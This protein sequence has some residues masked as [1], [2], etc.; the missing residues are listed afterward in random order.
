MKKNLL[1]GILLCLF[2]VSCSKVGLKTPTTGDVSESKTEET[3][4]N[5]NEAPNYFPIEENYLWEYDTTVNETKSDKI[6]TSKFAET[7]E[8]EGEIFHRFENSETVFGW[9]NEET[10][11]RKEGST[12]YFSGFLTIDTY[13]I[14][15]E[16]EKILEDIVSEE[17]IND[18]T[19]S[20]TLDKF[21]FSEFGLSGN[22]TP[23]LEANIHIKYIGKEALEVNG[24]QYNDVLKIQYTVFVKVVVGV[25]VS[26]V[27]LLTHTLI[28]KSPV[29]TLTQ[30][31]ANHIGCVKSILNVDG[32]AITFNN[33]IT[34]LG[35][36]IDASSFTS[37]IEEQVKSF[38]ETYVYTLKK[39]TK[40]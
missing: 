32:S 23:T 14:S 40:E 20:K 17:E 3:T 28:E 11:V 15:I 9:N 2:A 37:D 5:I 4:A 10:Y 38:K 16:N 39:L 19:V 22:L 27:N 7:K 35:Q 26:G 25:E 13:S 1:K 34:V 29:A 24:V 8:I 18:F 21:S 31:F 6:T 30:N 36:S 12:Y 33:K